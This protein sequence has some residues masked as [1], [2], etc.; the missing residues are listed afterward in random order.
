[1]KGEIGKNRFLGLDPSLKVLAGTEVEAAERLGNLEFR[2]A[3]VSRA[4]R[5]GAFDLILACDAIRDQADPRRILPGRAPASQAGAN[6]S[7]TMAR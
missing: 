2:Q 5:C 3:D 4:D 6:S 1:V 7:F